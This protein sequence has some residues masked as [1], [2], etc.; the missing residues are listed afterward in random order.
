MFELSKGFVQYVFISWI[1][2]DP[3]YVVHVLAKFAVVHRFF[4][5]GYFNMLS[6]TLVVPEQLR[7]NVSLLY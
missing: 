1:M 5:F 7:K 2:R 6:L 4:F 3:N